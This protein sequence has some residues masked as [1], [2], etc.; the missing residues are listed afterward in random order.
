MLIWVKNRKNGLRFN[1]E[2]CEKRVDDL[3]V[4]PLVRYLDS[5]VYLEM[6]ENHGAR[7]TKIERISQMNILKSDPRNRSET[8]S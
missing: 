4:T 1:S 7:I 3:L 8:S 2:V 6:V 5:S